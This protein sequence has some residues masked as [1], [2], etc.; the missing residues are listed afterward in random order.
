VLVGYLY[1]VVQ[2]KPMVRASNGR[3]RPPTQFDTTANTPLSVGTT[4]TSS[5]ADTAAALQ[6]LQDT[7]D[8]Q[9]TAFTAQIASITAMVQTLINTTSEQAGVCNCSLAHNS[10]LENIPEVH[11]D[12]T[13]N[14]STCPTTA[15]EGPNVNGEFR[16]V[17]VTLETHVHT[18]MNAAGVHI[19]RNITNS[20]RTQY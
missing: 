12:T 6:R 14:G 17:P 19:G 10:A 11:L 16:N 15:N 3:G 18:P 5:Q 8:Q 2:Y 20:H 1:V 9:Q 7:I 4:N 13:N